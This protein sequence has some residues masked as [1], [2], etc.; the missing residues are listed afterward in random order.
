[1]IYIAEMTDTFGGEANYSWVKRA[2]FEAP[3]NASSRSLVMR[4]KKQHGITGRHETDDFGD[5][6]V[7]RP[8]GQHVVIF[9]RPTDTRGDAK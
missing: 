9:V 6:V 8:R 5:E 2:W 4:A 7:I 1:M 3:D